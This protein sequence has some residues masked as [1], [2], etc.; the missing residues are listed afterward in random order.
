MCV[1]PVVHNLLREV[2]IC[3]C[4]CGGGGLLEN[5]DISLVSCV[6]AEYILSHIIGKHSCMQISIAI[7]FLVH[8]FH[9]CIDLCVFIMQF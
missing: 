4:V 9:F 6:H 7:P 3:V 5:D 1:W 8:Q 2:M